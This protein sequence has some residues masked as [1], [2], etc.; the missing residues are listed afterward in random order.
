MKAVVISVLYAVFE[1]TLSISEKKT[2]IVTKNLKKH[3]YKIDFV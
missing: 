2:I 3:I 1:Y